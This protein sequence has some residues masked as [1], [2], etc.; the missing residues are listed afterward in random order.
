VNAVI[1]AIHFVREVSE[2]AAVTDASGLALNDI[3]SVRLKAQTPL[4]ADTF[5]ALPA[6]G[7]FVLIDP[8]TNQTA[9]AGMI[10]EAH[11]VQPRIPEA[12]ESYEI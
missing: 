10:R 9:A 3:A 4:L 1:D 7:A 6:T 2:L 8:V 5:D 12:D 11:D